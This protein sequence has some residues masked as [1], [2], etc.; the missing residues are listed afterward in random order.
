MFEYSSIRARG[1]GDA[2]GCHAAARYLTADL[3]SINIGNNE[4]QTKFR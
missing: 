2:R 4:V 3:E 1:K